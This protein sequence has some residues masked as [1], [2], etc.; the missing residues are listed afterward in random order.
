M[1]T[2]L[3]RI[4][5]LFV[6]LGIQGCGPFSSPPE[7]KVSTYYIAPWVVPQLTILNEDERPV[8][9]ESVTVNGKYDVLYVWGPSKL[10]EFSKAPLETGQ[11]MTLRLDPEWPRAIHVK[12]RTNRGTIESKFEYSQ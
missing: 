11:S 12:V 2:L 10:T 4:V 9:I 1:K 8:V 7:L 3:A 5:V 6:A